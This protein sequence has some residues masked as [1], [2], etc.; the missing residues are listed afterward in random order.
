MLRTADDVVGGVPFA[1]QQQ[2]GLADGVGL[3]ID[4]L[5]IEVGGDFLAVVGGELLKHVLGHGQ[6]AASAASPIVD[7]V[8]AGLDLVGD[9]E[10]DQL[11]H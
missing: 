5:A 8:S 6:H 9:G 3:G 7:Q 1:L 2:V 11:R 4:L 10:E